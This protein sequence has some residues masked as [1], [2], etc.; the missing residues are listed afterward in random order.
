MWGG[1]GGYSDAGGRAL[2]Y[3]RL[4]T[5]S[6]SGCSLPQRRD[7]VRGFLLSSTVWQDFV[8]FF[9]FFKEQER[10]W[11]KSS[12][13]GFPGERRPP[14]SLGRRRDFQ[15]VPSFNR[16]NLVIIIPGRRRPILLDG[17]C[18]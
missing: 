4:G 1:G 6:S 5:V 11:T 13:I 15:Q 3:P 14:Q 18:I 8:C 7:G 17:S 12:L 16:A 10:G 9:G 2:G